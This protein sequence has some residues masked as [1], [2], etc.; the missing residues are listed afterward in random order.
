VKAAIATLAIG[1]DYQGAYAR[2]FRPSV[3]RYAERH[4]YDLLQFDD[5]LGDG[6]FHAPLFIYLMKMLLP[7]QDAVRDYDRLMVLDVDI[8]VHPE[9]PPFHALEIDDGI[10][11]VDEWSQPSPAERLAIQRANGWSTSLR[12]YYGRAGL[13]LASDTLVN[14]GMYVCCPARHADFFR[15]VTHRRMAA[16][17]D[18]PPAFHQYEQA[19]FGYELQMAGLVRPLPAAWNR[20]WPLHRPLVTAGAAARIELFRQFLTL[21]DASFM[22]HLTGGQDHDF[23]FAIRN[24]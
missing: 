8:L 24:R 13:D 21:R 1:A 12:H 6:A 16:R 9:A 22:L 20:L 18:F 4:G 3:Q 23:A 5:Y 10:G 17:R 19:V 14:S 7:L 15:D 2:I 11:V